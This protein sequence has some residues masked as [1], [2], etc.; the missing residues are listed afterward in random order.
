MEV[1]ADELLEAASLSCHH[2]AFLFMESKPA[3]LYLG[4][5]KQRERCGVFNGDVF[6]YHWDLPR[7][8]RWN[9]LLLLFCDIRSVFW[10]PQKKE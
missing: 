5:E 1:H 4:T 2:H 8:K 10:M 7:E 6:T 9:H 3:A